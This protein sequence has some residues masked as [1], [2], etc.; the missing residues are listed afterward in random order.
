MKRR[1][2]RLLGPLLV[3][4]IIALGGCAPPESGGGDGGAP[5]NADDGY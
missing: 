1:W 4:S 2:M 5:A 3:A